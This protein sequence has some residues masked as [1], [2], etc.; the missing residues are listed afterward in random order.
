MKCAAVPLVAPDGKR[1]EVWKWP[2]QNG[3]PSLHWA[4]ATGFCAR[5]YTP[6]LDVLAE[7]FNVSAWD[8]RGHGASRT[9]GDP[10]TFR[11]WETGYRD[12]TAML[13]QAAEPMWL[14]GHSIGATTSLAA[15][16]RRPDKVKGLILVEPVILDPRE[17]WMLRLA[18]LL[19]LAHRFKL[20]A[21]ASRRRARFASRQL[22]YENYR[23][24]SAFRNWPDTWLAAYTSYGLIDCDGGEVE[25]AC[26]PAWEALT[27][28]HTE[29][30][31]W[32]WLR[33]LHC[34]IHVIAG[35]R[36]STFPV[37]M[38]DRLQKRFGQSQIQ[39]IEKTSHFLPMERPDLVI[40]QCLKVITSRWPKLLTSLLS[41]VALPV[42]YWQT[43]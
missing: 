24:K 1:L 2:M 40:E 6:L 34:P 9:A 29:H 21:G 15:A 43:D 39:L 7:S 17:G 31:A 32:R 11:G 23:A 4:H 26:T 35:E 30:N 5:T 20:A 27:F 22:A 3:R 25:L 10:A 14:A 18:R 33:E 19:G 13:D 8:M 28:I 42:A 36:G 37:A 16:M 41:A 12:L 38:H